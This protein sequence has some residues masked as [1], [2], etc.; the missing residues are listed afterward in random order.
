M[1]EKLIDYIV[2]SDTSL[3]DIDIEEFV[4]LGN[5]TGVRVFPT[6]WQEIPAGVE[7]DESPG[8]EEKGL[9]RY[10][11]PKTKGMLYAQASGASGWSRRPAVWL[12]V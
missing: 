10:T 12:R 7:T 1:R 11:K 4:S 8:E 3:F 9:V 2:P 6:L 5:R